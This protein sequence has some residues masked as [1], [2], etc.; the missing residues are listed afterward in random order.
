MINILICDDCP[1]TVNLLKNIVVKTYEE[2]EMDL[3][4]FNI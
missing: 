1:Q 2:E 4:E 3:C